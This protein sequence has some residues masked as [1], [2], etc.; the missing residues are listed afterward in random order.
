MQA[1][2][3]RK[4]NVCRGCTSYILQSSN[5]GERVIK[6]MILYAFSKHDITSQEEKIEGESLRSII[7]IV[8]NA[9]SLPSPLVSFISYH[10]ISYFPSI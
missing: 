3:I 1:V 7:I 9:S 6:Y 10:I 5:F 2:T 4:E 8:I